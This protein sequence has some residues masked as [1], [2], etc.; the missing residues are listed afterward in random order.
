MAGNIVEWLRGMAKY[1]RKITTN[2]YRYDEAADEIE[3]LRAALQQIAN[4]DRYGH[5]WMY[6]R[7]AREALERVGG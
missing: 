3:R 7:I 1:T 4:G 2:G 5:G 6:Q